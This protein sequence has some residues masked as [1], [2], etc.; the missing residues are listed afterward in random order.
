MS[1][2]QQQV[3][4][5]LLMLDREKQ[6]S[7]HTLSAYRSDLSQFAVFM[8]RK[9]SPLFTRKDV[10]RYLVLLT[11][12]G[13]AASSRVRKTV[14]VRR[15]AR[16]LVQTGVR[17]DNPFDEI[18]TVRLPRHLPEYLSE[19]DVERLLL[20]P[21]PS[22]PIGSRDSA[23]LE[24]MYASGLRVTELIQTRFQDVR[25]EESFLVV[26]GKG[27]KERIVPV[28]EVA[29]QAIERYLTEGRGQLER[30]RQNEYLFL[31]RLGKPLSRQG[32]WKI[33]KGYCV[34]IG[35]SG[36]ISPHTLRHSFATHLVEHGADLRS[37][38]MMLG[39][40]DISTTEIYTAVTREKMRA[41]YDRFHPL[42]A[43]SHKGK[44]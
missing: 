15:F 16:Y 10:D 40:S 33:I 34:R 32:V 42:S 27:R 35:L 21:D 12:K 39:H 36:N 18:R 4:L 37:V 26:M 1:D 11:K 8:G 17:E 3:E 19:E 5:F 29:M 20:A 9:L 7:T 13:L 28:G 6:A 43:G 44:D 41:D 2:F 31:N 14:S 23:M 38:Q 30:G 25:R 24:L 22:V